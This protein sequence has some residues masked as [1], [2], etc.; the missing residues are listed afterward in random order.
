MNYE[1]ALE[2]LKKYNQTHLLVGY[3]ELT[4]GQKKELLESI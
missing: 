3:N 2:L 1:E 4:E